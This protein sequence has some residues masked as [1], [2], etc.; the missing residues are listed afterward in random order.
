MPI[1]HRELEEDVYPN[2]TEFFVIGIV[3]LVLYTIVTL[4][5]GY[6]LF[7]NRSSLA[8]SKSVRDISFFILML[9][10][11]LMSI[12]WYIY[13]KHPNFFDITTQLILFNC[14]II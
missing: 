8:A 2:R 3:A 10:S 5:A 1:L 12:P 11:G 14:F 4:I 6:G 9:I 13:S 7:R